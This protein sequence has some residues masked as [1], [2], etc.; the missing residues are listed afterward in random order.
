MTDS[1]IILVNNIINE[2]PTNVVS[3]PEEISA[4]NLF[5]EMPVTNVPENNVVTHAPVFHKMPVPEVPV[6]NMVSQVPTTQV[7]V[8]NVFSPVVRMLFLKFQLVVL[9]LKYQLLK[10]Q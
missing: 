2:V 9:F 10:Y 4:T 1:S 5:S 3:P 7:P 6:S 8:N